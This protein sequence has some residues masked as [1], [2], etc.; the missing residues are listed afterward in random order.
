M[1]VSGASDRISKCGNFPSFTFSP[2]CGLIA[3]VARDKPS[4]SRFSPVRIRTKLSLNISPSSL[5][6]RAAGRRTGSSANTSM[7][8]LELLRRIPRAKTK[9]PASPRRLYR[10]NT[11]KPDTIVTTTRNIDEAIRSKQTDGDVR[12][13]TASISLW[14]TSQFWPRFQAS[15]QAP[16]FLVLR[17]NY[18][19]SAQPP[20]HVPDRRKSAGRCCCRRGALH[21]EPAMSILPRHARSTTL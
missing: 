8:F 15:C 4:R 9:R 6:D 16:V 2:K 12:S 13:A 5:K 10:Y 1:R 18:P 20:R 7:I 3:I 19:K 17:A 11:T 21:L 14:A